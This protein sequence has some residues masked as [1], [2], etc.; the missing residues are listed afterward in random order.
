MNSP[1]ARDSNSNRST[2]LAILPN[3][4]S[5][6][7][8]AMAGAWIHLASAP[9]NRGWL[10]AIA[11]GGAA[12]DYIDGPI[13]RWIGIDD[14][15]GRWLDPVADVVFVLAAL[16]SEAHRR[17]VPF[18]IPIL[19]AIAFAQYA[20]D[21]MLL[22]RTGGPIR[23]RIGHWGGIVNYALVLVAGLLGDTGARLISAIAPALAAF[24]VAGIAERAIAYRSGEHRL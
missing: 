6:S 5:A 12:S 21:S 3:I 7:R 10:G 2:A 13:A 11:V 4:L 18:Y 9:G 20:L 15:A 1:A 24:Y 23:S 22:H 17:A 8:L 19:I 16:G 14:G